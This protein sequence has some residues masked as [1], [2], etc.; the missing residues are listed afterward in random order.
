MYQF[1]QYRHKIVGLLIPGVAKISPIAQQIL[2]RSN[3]PYLRTTNHTTGKLYR[4]ISE[5]VY[6]LTAEDVEKIDMI[7]ELAEVR[8]DFDSLDRQFS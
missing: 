6:K 7:R 4:L 5:D 1:P 8:L 3:I 2:D